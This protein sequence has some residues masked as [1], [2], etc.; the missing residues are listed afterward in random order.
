MAAIPPLE[1]KY[2]KNKISLLNA[3]VQIAENDESRREE[4]L[5]Y[6]K[7][8]DRD[9]ELQL[10][11][12]DIPSGLTWFNSSPLSLKTDLRGK[13]IVLDFFTYCCINCMH[14][15]PDLAELEE[16]HSIEDGLVIIG[17]HSAKF[18]NEKLSENISNAIRRYDIHHPC[19]KRQ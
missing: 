19:G 4:I 17:V 9:T 1:R 8:A 10:D 7:S 14:I 2:I 12:M 13:L 16:S 6:I 15:L 5:T 11:G 3:A 18:L